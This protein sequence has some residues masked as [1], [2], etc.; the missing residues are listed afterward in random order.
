MEYKNTS[1]VVNDKENKQVFIDIADTLAE[2]PAEDVIDTI[3][4]DI[5]GTYRIHYIT[6]TFETLFGFLF[7]EF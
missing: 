2:L 7:C 4:L 3:V 1:G 5:D 6:P